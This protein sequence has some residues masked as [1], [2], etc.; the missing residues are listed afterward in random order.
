MFQLWEPA[1]AW[2][3]KW[4]ACSCLGM[5]TCLGGGKGGKLVIV[6]CFQYENTHIFFFRNPHKEEEPSPIEVPSVP[7]EL[8]SFE[9]RG[10]GK[11]DIEHLAK[12][13][14]EHVK[15]GELRCTKGKIQ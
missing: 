1:L 11:M 6:A 3:G 13:W 5:E 14:R 7:T 8:W 10:E 4:R 12:K 9:P 15:S 2:E